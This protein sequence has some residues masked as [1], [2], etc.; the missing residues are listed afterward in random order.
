MKSITNRSDRAEPEVATLGAPV[1]KEAF[2]ALAVDQPVLEA[3]RL[4]LRPLS[5]DDA[6]TVAR[7]AGRREI[8]DT[9][10]SIPHPYSE[11]QAREWIRMI[12]GQGT[13]RERVFAIL[14]N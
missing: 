8:A 14:M 12:T 1:L 13:D 6:P 7:L 4:T 5:S 3:V 10:L 2:S 9:T 11:Q